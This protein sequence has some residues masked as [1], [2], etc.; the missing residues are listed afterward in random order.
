MARTDRTVALAGNPNTGKTSLF[1]A[2]TGSSQHTGNWPG[3][4]VVRREGALHHQ[5]I[6]MLVVDLPGTYSITAISPEEAIARDYLL[7]GEA[8]AVVIV[9]DAANLERNLY[10]ATQILEIGLPAVVA[11]N[12]VDVAERRR[13][14]VDH[15][16]LAEHLGVAVVPTV[17]RTDEGIDELRDALARLNV[18]AGTT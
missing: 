16:T 12:M 10:L 6:D 4:T 2:L 9:V 8:D 11:L 1:N 7:S 14:P 17:A 13:E 5:G 18:G 15:E 3:K